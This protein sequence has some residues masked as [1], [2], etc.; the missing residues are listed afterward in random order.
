MPTPLTSA[1]RWVKNSDDVLHHIAV[2]WCRLH[3]VRLP[4][5]MHHAERQTAIRRSLQRLW[6]LR[7][8]RTSFRRPAPH[9]ADSLITLGVLVSTE[10]IVS[11][12]RASTSTAVTTRSN[13]SASLTSSGARTGRFSTNIQNVGT[14]SQ[15]FLGAGEKR[16]GVDVSIAVQLS[17]IGKGVWSDVENPH[18]ARTAQV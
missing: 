8:P 18:D 12:C 16:I 17:A 5:H 11:Q 4:L 15:H 2:G 9:R 10:M 3:R 1:R 14:F 7:K 6:A 13:S